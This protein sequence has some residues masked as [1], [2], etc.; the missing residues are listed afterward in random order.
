[1]KRIT[2]IENLEI[3]I[4]TESSKKKKN[5]FYIILFDM[6]KVI[7]EVFKKV[8]KNKCFLNKKKTF[9]KLNMESK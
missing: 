9:K 4:I 2:N 8:N 7:K 3:M 5:Y 1:M 6:I